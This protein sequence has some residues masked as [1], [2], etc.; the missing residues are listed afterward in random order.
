MEVGGGKGTSD[1][2]EED[3]EDVATV[4][5][6]DKRGDKKL[7]AKTLTADS[8]PRNNNEDGTNPTVAMAR[9]GD[10]RQRRRR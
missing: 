6:I 1:N 3:T 8:K 5:D 9:G 10:L 4:D 7:T 2:E